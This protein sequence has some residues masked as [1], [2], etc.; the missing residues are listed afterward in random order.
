[1]RK[2]YNIATISQSYKVSVISIKIILK[3]PFFIFHVLSGCLVDLFSPHGLWPGLC[4]VGTL[5][6]GVA[7]EH[8]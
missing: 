5:K 7:R 4:R 3:F 2:F 6:M 1:M 8:P